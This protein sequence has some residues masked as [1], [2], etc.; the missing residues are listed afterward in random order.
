MLPQPADH[1]GYC[2]HSFENHRAVAI[3][4]GKK[5][6]GE[7]PQEPNKAIGDF[8]ACSFR[9]HV[10]FQGTVKVNRSRRRRIKGLMRDH[11]DSRSK[12]LRDG[13]RLAAYS[14]DIRLPRPK[15][16]ATDVAAAM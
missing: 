11:N 3:T 12:A 5:C 16:T 2:G 15:T 14:L 6:I 7:K 4:L 13:H 8:I 10:K 1:A 9:F